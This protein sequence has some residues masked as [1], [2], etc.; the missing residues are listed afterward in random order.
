VGARDRPE[1]TL[2]APLG[3]GRGGEDA[4]LPKLA[5]TAK[6]G[7]SGQFSQFG[8]GLASLGPVLASLASLVSLSRIDLNYDS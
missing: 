1:P 7:Y 6:R 8:P 2:L 3:A 4:F 5:Q